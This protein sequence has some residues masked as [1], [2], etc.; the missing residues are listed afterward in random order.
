MRKLI[1]TLLLTCCLGTVAAQDCD[2]LYGGWL[3]LQMQ[4]HK[5]GLL[6]GNG[7]CIDAAVVNGGLEMVGGTLSIID[8]DTVGQV[9]RWTGTTWE[10]RLIIF[11][12]AVSGDTSY[13]GITYVVGTPN[14]HKLG[15]TLT[16]NTTISGVN[17]RTLTLNNLHTLSIEAERTSG[18]GRTTMDFGSTNVSG[19][20]LFHTL[21]ADPNQ[22]AN[23]NVNATTGNLFR[24]QGAANVLTQLLQ[25]W[26]GASHVTDITS[27]DGTTQR[28][29]R[30]SKTG[31]FITDLGKVGA[32]S[33]PGVMMYDT[34]TGEIRYQSP[35]ILLRNLP[36]IG[37][38]GQTL[39]HN[40]TGWIANSTIYNDGTNVGIGTT[41]PARLLHVAGAARITSSAGT[42]ILPMGR[43]AN[44]DVSNLSLAGGLYVSSGTLYAPGRP[45]NEILYGNGT[46]SAPSSDSTFQYDRS[47]RWVTFSD[48]TINHASIRKR[49]PWGNSFSTI[50]GTQWRNRVQVGD[51]AGVNVTNRLAFNVDAA[52]NPEIF[53]STG[54][55]SFDS[56]ILAI[57]GSHPSG[58]QIGMTTPS[59]ADVLYHGFD[60]NAFF[61]SKNNS[62]QLMYLHKDAPSYSIYM[63]SAGKVGINN[64]GPGV[65]T[66]DV[67]QRSNDF[68]GGIGLRST[69]NNYG[70]WYRDN[71]NNMYLTENA[72]TR[73]LWGTGGVFQAYGLIHAGESTYTGDNGIVFPLQVTSAANTYK[74]GAYGLNPE[75]NVTAS[76][77]AIVVNV[78]AGDL[79]QKRTTSGNTGWGKVLNIADANGA[80]TDSALIWNGSAWE[81]GQVGANTI[82]ST[83][84]T[85]GTYGGDGDYVSITVDED[86][87]VTSAATHPYDNNEYGNGTHT[88][89]PSYIHVYANAD[90]GNVTLN[91]SSP[92]SEGRDYF[93]AAL[94]NGTNTVTLSGTLYV[95]GVGYA[96]SYELD[97]WE[98]VTVR[99]RDAWSAWFIDK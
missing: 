91:L 71:S 81:P 78:G 10:P 83:G 67:I 92:F 8:G 97:P 7:Y 22:L 32:F 29:L 77:G 18:T 94:N 75:G 21:T 89:N 9:L 2:T 70:V 56:T 64:N 19:A 93:C 15:G 58:L 36:G 47:N 55:V 44:G 26:D 14:A 68:L 80:A 42:A 6:F 33:E 31:V 73:Y 65:G 17:T 95:D 66:L 54:A 5:L 87:R 46:S 88:W 24:L 28:T 86:G 59:T 43:D 98:Q 63:N 11:P 38:S 84:V 82:A 41:S 61:L 74:I 20:S 60:G 90:V 48:K 13:N 76:R 3:E 27:T 1:Y 52:S 57:N 79:Y 30:V 34:L 53:S 51:S 25:Y 4:T 49:K 45:T 85:A 40:G 72:S 96:P 50:I 62:G 23:M 37:T 12:D 16:E 69:G 39:R 35:D 99:Y